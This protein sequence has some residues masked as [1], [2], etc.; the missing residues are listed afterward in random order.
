MEG[1]STPE[2]MVEYLY[3]EGDKIMGS[4]NLGQPYGGANYGV[5]ITWCDA[6]GNFYEPEFVDA[7]VSG[8]GFGV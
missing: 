3:A 2:Q 1:I 8:S 7:N 4:A 6:E 5:F